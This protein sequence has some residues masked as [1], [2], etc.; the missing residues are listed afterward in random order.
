[1]NSNYSLIEFNINKSMFLENVNIQR[2]NT[3][4]I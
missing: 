4:L 1:M 3:K 2:L